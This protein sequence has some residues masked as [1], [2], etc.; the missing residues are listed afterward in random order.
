MNRTMPPRAGVETPAYHRRPLPGPIQ[1]GMLFISAPLARLL[2][3]LTR[4]RSRKTPIFTAP[5]LRRSSGPRIIARPTVF[6]GVSKIDPHGFSRG[7]CKLPQFKKGKSRAQYSCSNAVP[8]RIGIHQPSE[9]NR[10]VRFLGI[11]VDLAWP[12]CV[13]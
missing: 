9:E 11:G 4:V 12:P 10:D 2:P 1:F 5:K 6:G 13:L 8:K 3:F 7:L